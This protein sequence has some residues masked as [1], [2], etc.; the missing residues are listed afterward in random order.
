LGEELVKK[1]LKTLCLTEKEV[2]VYIFIAKHGVLK[3]SEIAKGMKRHKSQ[4]Y[5]ILKILQS[6]GLI[7]ATL[8][9]P[10]RFSAVP[11]ENVLDLSIKAKLDEAA[12][13]ESAKKDVLTYWNSINHPELDEP[14]EKFIVIEGSDKIYPR[15]SQMIKE[16]RNQLLFA[17]TVSGLICADKFGFFDSIDM[18]PQ[19]A[20]IEFNFITDQSDDDCSVDYAKSFVNK[21]PKTKLNFKTRKSNAKSNMSPRVIIRDNEEILFFITP[22]NS[23]QTLI[24]DDEVCLWTNCKELVHVFTAVFEDLWRNST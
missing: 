14:L 12:C 8:E 6:K 3:C 13:I 4:I 17:S 16:T 24:Q 23:A 15:I 19:K 5:R 22:Q 18:H 21:L 7:E 1:I 2:E 10:C 9:A 11:L 20:N